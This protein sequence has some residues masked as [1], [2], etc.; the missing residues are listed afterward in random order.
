MTRKRTT[1]I[2]TVRQREPLSAIC[3]MIILCL[4]MPAAALPQV[5]EMRLKSMFLEAAVRFVIWPE[6]SD[7]VTGTGKRDHFSIGF[8]HND[9]FAREFTTLVARKWIKNRPVRFIT[10][11]NQ[12]NIDSCDLVI[13]PGDR[14]GRASKVLLRTANKPVLTVSDNPSFVDRGVILCIGIEN[15]RISCY[16]N[17]TAA[18]SS[19]LKISHHLLRKSTVT[20]KPG[21]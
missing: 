16:I 2:D 18:A 13:I 9:K 7:T 15:Q 8:F 14:R 5:K 1:V 20:S 11:E 12:A 6:A 3:R 19:R 21:E 10:I 17:Q 4:L